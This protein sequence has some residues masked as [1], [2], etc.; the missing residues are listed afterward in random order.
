VLWPLLGLLWLWR[1]AWSPAAIRRSQKRPD[2]AGRRRADCWVL[3]NATCSGW[4]VSRLWVKRPDGAFSGNWSV[5]LVPRI[6]VWSRHLSRLRADVEA[7]VRTSVRSLRSVRVRGRY[8]HIHREPRPVASIAITRIGRKGGCLMSR[9][10]AV[11]VALV[12]ALV[13]ATIG[14]AAADIIADDDDVLPNPALPIGPGPLYRLD[15]YGPTP[16]DNVVLRWDEQ[17][18]AA[19][20]A[21]KPGPT[22]VAR[23]W[24]WCTPACTTRGRPTTR[25]RSAPAWAARCGGRPA[26]APWPE[27]AR[28]SATPPTARC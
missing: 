7:S 4:R 8:G 28:R 5:C 2:R 14:H 11:T 20:R 22:I 12:A 15:A 19:V 3:D 23:R 16:D 9:R 21:V 24:P 27:R 1:R 26:S 17:T 13:V 25:S 6:C 10:L 18:L